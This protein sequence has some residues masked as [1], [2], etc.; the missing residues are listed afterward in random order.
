VT[1]IE[2]V[3]D[4]LVEM[5]HEKVAAKGEPLFVK[6]LENVQGDERDFIFISMTYGPKSGKKEVLQRFG[7]INGKQ[8]YRRLNVLLQDILPHFCSASTSKKTPSPF[9]Q[10]GG[11]ALSGKLAL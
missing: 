1:I 5:Y 6:N 4:T 8:G 7:P 11:S 9:E 3:R 2:A 10:G